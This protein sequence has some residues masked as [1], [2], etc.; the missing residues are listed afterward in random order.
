MRHSYLI[1]VKYFFLS[2]S[3]T[4]CVAFPEY[5][6]VKVKINPETSVS[7]PTPAQLGRTI[8][9]QQLITA[10]WQGKTQSLSVHLK[11]Y[12]ESVLLIG[13]TT[14]GNRIFTLKYSKEDLQEESITGLDALLP[15]GEKVLLNM[16][17]ALW[18]EKSW[19]APLARVGWSLVDSENTRVLFDNK[20]E[21]IIK[22]AYSEPLESPRIPRLITINHTHDKYQIIINTVN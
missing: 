14:W 8:S 19:K 4:G 12:K 11:A 1:Y 15:D 2:L 5:S 17:L 16:M 10:N 22:I 9:A 7:L 21:I 13:L 6:F 18:P 20:G 3:L